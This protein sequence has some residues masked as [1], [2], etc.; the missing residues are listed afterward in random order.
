MYISFLSDVRLANIFSHS[1]GCLFSF[2][3]GFLCFAKTFIWYNPTCVFFSCCLFFWYHIQKKKKKS[4]PILK[5][6]KFFLYSPRSFKV[7]FKNLINFELIFVSGPIL[8]F[9]MC[10]SS[11]TNTIYQNDYI[12]PIVCSCL[13]VLCE[14][15]SGVCI[16]FHWSVCLFLCQYHTVCIKNLM[17]EVEKDTNKL[18]SSWYFSNT[19]WTLWMHLYMDIFQ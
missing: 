16:L 17:K 4:L 14:F 9:G 2:L 12:F 1:V 7:M 3:D 6:R 5:S 18:K 8:L 19:V 10:I 13:K 15:L 11:F